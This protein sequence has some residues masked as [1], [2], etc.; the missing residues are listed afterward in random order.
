MSYQQ[1]ILAC[2]AKT[3]PL[4]LKRANLG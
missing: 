2:Q 3:S 4:K 1:L